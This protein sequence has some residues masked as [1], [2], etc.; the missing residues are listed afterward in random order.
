MYWLPQRLRLTSLILGSA[1]MTLKRSC[2]GVSI[3]SISPLIRAFI[4]V[5]CSEIATHSTR[6]TFAILP[7]AKPEGGPAAR[8]VFGILDVDR[9]VAR[10]PLI[11][12]EDER[13]RAGG[14]VDLLERIGLG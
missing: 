2:C 8:L 5:C 11:P 1:S 3:M 10:L 7:P 4:A 14:V 6:S 12:E 9:L 13:A